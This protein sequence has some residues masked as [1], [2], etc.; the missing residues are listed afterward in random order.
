MKRNLLA[1]A[2][3][4]MLVCASQAASARV[5]LN[6]GV[7]IPGMIYGQPPPVVYAAPPVYQA[8]PVVYDRGRYWDGDHRGWDR[9]DH[10]RHGR[11]DHGDHG[12][13]GDRHDHGH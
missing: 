4:L 2:L 1:S 6:I 11:G 10:G 12:D 8:P 3:G 7:G 9:H 13:H 5:D